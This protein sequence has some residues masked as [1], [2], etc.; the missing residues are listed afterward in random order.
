LKNGC[1]EICIGVTTIAKGED[2]VAENQKME[3]VAYIYVLHAIL[4]RPH[5]ID[6]NNK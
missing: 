5:I 2:Q 3:R 1:N 4:K 6:S